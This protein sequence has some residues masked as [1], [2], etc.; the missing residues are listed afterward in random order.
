MGAE[1][2][3]A[4]AA[5]VTGGR[6]NDGESEARG[7][8]CVYRVAAGAENFNPGIGGQM[9]HADHHAVLSKDRLLVEIRQH[10][11]CALLG[12]DAMCAE[13]EGDNGAEHLHRE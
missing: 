5:Q 2:H 1:Q 7:Y 8:G 9:M 10:V 4:A 12:E 3:E 11:F 13:R 6:M